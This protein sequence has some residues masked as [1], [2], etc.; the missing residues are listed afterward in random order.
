MRSL[1]FAPCR[2]LRVV[3]CLVGVAFVWCVLL[4]VCVF[5]RLLFVMCCLLRVVCYVLAG[6]CHL[7]CVDFDCF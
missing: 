3:C 2:V 7:L 5:A 4:V 1:V 6:V